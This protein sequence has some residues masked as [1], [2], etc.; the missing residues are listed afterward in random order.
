MLMGK[1]IDQMKVGDA[2]EFAKTVT[3]TDI[4]LFAGITGD[5]NP[6]HLNEAYAKDTFFKT[7]R[8]H[9]MLSEVL[10]PQFWALNCPVP[11]QFT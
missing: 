10:S 3:E 7:R 11:E 8:A 5:F 4:Y 9:G 2:A 1:T 6:A